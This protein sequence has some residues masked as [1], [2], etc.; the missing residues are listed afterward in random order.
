[1]KNSSTPL[2]AAVILLILLSIGPTMFARGGTIAPQASNYVTGKVTSVYSGRPVRS[3]W[4][5]VKQGENEKGRSLTG[6]DGSYYIGNLA[7]GQYEIVATKGAGQRSD[8]VTL[9]QNKVFNIEINF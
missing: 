6:D 2:A 4:V 7:D 5:I 8:V 3:V 9:P 1:M